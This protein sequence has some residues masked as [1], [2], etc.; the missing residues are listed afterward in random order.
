MNTFCFAT[1]LPPR[2]HQTPPPDGAA[3]WVA[4]RPGN[5]SDAPRCSL[6][7]LAAPMTVVMV[8]VPMVAAPMVAALPTDEQQ[9]NHQQPHPVF[10][11]PRPY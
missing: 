2:G 9:S 1:S 3:S 8:M 7:A 4:F 6:G 11:V 5:A 10:Y